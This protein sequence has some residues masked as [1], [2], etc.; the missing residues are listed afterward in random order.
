MAA[1]DQTHMAECSTNWWDCVADVACVERTLP[2]PPEAYV[3]DAMENPITYV[4]ALQQPASF[5]DTPTKKCCF[6]YVGDEAADNK[7]GTVPSY[8]NLQDRMDDAIRDGVV[9][10]LFDWTEW[11][12]E[13]GRARFNLLIGGTERDDHN[14]PVQSFGTRRAGDGDFTVDLASFS[15]GRVAG[16]VGQIEDGELVA[17]SPSAAILFP[18]T[19]FGHYVGENIAVTLQQ[20]QVEATLT[21]EVDGIH[22]VDDENFED[23]YVGGGRLGGMINL[24]DF[25]RLYGYGHIDE[26]E[27][28]DLV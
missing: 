6:D 8:V 2:I 23:E 20:A 22:T 18:T 1:C 27:W 21:A 5:E 19:L 17:E 25:P 16:F 28:R 13:D 3:A 10:L 11:P 9:T 14:D 24:W 4:W 12:E 26:C 7:L 15:E